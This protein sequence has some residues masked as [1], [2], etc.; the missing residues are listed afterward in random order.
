MTKTTTKSRY[1]I[2]KGPL[3]AIRRYLPS[4]YQADGPANG[5]VL[6]HG[7]DNA[8]WTLDEYVIPRLASGMHY[9]QEIGK[10]EALRHVYGGGVP[11]HAFVPGDG[12]MTHV[13]TCQFPGC[14]ADISE[15]E[16][17]EPCCYVAYQTRGAQHAADCDEYRP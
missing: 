5:T 6:I 14:G 13:T 12:E 17:G 8:G 15:H 9:A 1:A 4:N 11:E 10:A 7:H 3:E 2:V 16:E